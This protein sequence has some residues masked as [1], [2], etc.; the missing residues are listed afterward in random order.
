[1]LPCVM[2][3]EYVS[4]CKTCKNMNIPEYKFEIVF[5]E[6]I[7]SPMQL[8]E[9][10]SNLVLWRKGEN[11]TERKLDLLVDQGIETFQVKLVY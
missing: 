8:N 2:H 10:G 3:T 5:A 6:D 11:I 1:M 4:D 7:L 9:D